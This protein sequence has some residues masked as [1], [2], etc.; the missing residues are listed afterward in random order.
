MLV[1]LS[2]AAFAGKDNQPT[3]LFLKKEGKRYLLATLDSS[4]YP[5]VTLDLN[6]NPLDNVS[7]VSSNAEIHLTGYCEPFDEDSLL[8]E[9]A[10]KQKDK[11]IAQTKLTNTQATEDDLKDHEVKPKG[12]QKQEQQKGA[13]P[14]QLNQNVK[15]Q[16]QNTKIEVKGTQST[17]TTTHQNKVQTQKPG[18]TQKVSVQ[19]SP[20]KQQ[21]KNEPAKKKEESEEEELDDE[22]LDDLDDDDLEGL[23]DEDL[24][25]EDEEEE[26]EKA[27]AKKHDKKNDKKKKEDLE[28]DDLDELDD[29]DL[30]GLEDEDLEEEEG[31]LED[32][33]DEE[34]EEEE[35]EEDLKKRQPPAKQ[36]N[37]DHKQDF[38]NKPD[39]KNKNNNFHKGGFNKSNNHGGFNKGNRNNDRQGGFNKGGRGHQGGFNKG[40]KGN[41][42]NFKKRN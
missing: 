6:I 37:K 40:G 20:N 27:P 25:D 23:D 7:L 11:A 30:E 19:P 29:E 24:D 9:D 42:G 12:P 14:N 41:H 31:D 1:H 18:E 38:K 33:E 32:E 26:E 15:Q 34:E 3:S 17:P 4:R 22:D 39:F 5:Q 10:I 2:N 8:I 21:A 36:F 13:Q 16:A 35:E 28:E